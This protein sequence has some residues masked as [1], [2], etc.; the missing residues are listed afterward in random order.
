MEIINR[1]LGKTGSKC[2]VLVI[3]TADIPCDVSYA[4]RKALATRNAGETGRQHYWVILPGNAGPNPVQSFSRD[5]LRQELLKL[6]A[7]AR[8]K[9]AAI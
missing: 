2:K 3:T 7:A 6:N 8:A 1:D 9:K 4:M 5:G